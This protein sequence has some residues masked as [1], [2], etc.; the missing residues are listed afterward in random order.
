MTDPDATPQLPDSADGPSSGGA[1]PATHVPGRA[2]EPAPPGTFDGRARSFRESRTRERSL[3]RERVGQIVVV[4]IIILGIYAIVSAKPFNPSSNGG[5]PNPGPP[6]IVNFSAPVA[7][8]VPCA[9][10]GTGYTERLVW[11]NSSAPVTTGDVGILIKEPDN[12]S[13]PDQGVVA[14]ATSSNVC[15]GSPPNAVTWSWYVV[16]AAPNGTNILTYTDD[17]GWTSVTHGP[18]NVPI[19]DGTT[20][21]IVT[22]GPFYHRGF[23]FWLVGY[24]NGSPIHR[25]V[26]L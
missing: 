4:A 21:V 6:I 20:W 14:N 5:N 25:T 18:S 16:L 7:G 12:D 10:G 3:R 11:T 19:E 15:A 13:V 1:G 2:G 17:H 8:Q 9:G 23:V 26:V 22:G 24:A